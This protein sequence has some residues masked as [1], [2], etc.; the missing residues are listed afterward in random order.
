MT[1]CTINNNGI[2]WQMFTKHSWNDLSV[3]LGEMERQQ[4]MPM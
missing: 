3:L 2:D 4:S 1:E